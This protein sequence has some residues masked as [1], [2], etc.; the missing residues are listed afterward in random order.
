MRKILPVALLALALSAL[1]PARV[2]AW[3]FNGHK[4]IAGRALDLLPPQIRPFFQKYRVTIVEHS[5]DPDTYRTVGWSE[6]PPRHF[7]DMDSYGPFPFTDLPHD[8]Q[9]AV[10]ARGS[11]FVVKNGLLP[12]RAQEMFD[13]LRDAFRQL[14]TSPYARDN[15]KLFA[16][17]IAHYTADSF[18][19]FHA[20]ANY[21]GQMTGQQGIH[22]RFESELFDRYQSRMRLAPPPL[23]R[24]A[25]AR[26][27]V[28][29]TLTDSFSF[30]DP[31]L[32]ADR[33]AVRDRQFYDDAYFAK[34]YQTSGPIMEKRVAAAASGVA[35]M[36]TQAW[37]DAGRPALPVTAPPRPPRAIRR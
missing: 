35:S 37:I 28:F 17:V 11:D 10:A 14:P 21:D 1:P 18:Q 15:V 4:F 33:D 3:G 24:I 7:L 34:L 2:G 26:D 29:A 22:S 32:A 5:I 25:S 36:I 20:A 19:P 23:T 30:V 31:I 13:Q 27:F 6:E 12:W 16:A 9:A 8:Y